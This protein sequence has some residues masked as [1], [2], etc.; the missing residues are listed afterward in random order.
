MSVVDPGAALPHELGQTEQVLDVVARFSLAHQDLS[1]DLFYTRRTQVGR[2]V[3]CSDVNQ[4]LDRGLALITRDELDHPGAVASS[5][6]F[7]YVQVGEGLL[8]L[9]AGHLEGYAPG[10]GL[11]RKGGG[12]KVTSHFNIISRY[13]LTDFLEV[14]ISFKRYTLTAYSV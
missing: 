10:A 1:S 11:Q 9:G 7:T 4:S 6:G 13:F 12:V 14:L 2:V 3:F 5:Y 8:D